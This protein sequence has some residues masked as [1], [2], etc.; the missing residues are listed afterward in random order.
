MAKKEE[1]GVDVDL[2]QKSKIDE[3]HMSKCS[4]SDK[5]RE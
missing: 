3:T 1:D 2:F 4:K 5:Q